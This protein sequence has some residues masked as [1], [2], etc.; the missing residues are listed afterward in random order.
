[1]KNREVR[2]GHTVEMNY[3]T[4]PDILDQNKNEDGVILIIFWNC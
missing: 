2:F 1:M 4:F 3:D